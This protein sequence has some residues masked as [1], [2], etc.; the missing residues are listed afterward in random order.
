[1]VVGLSMKN[2]VYRRHDKDR[3]AY[4]DEME[5]ILD[6]LRKHGEIFVPDTTIESLYYDFSYAKYGGGWI[7][8]N[9]QILEEFEAWLNNYE[10]I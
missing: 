3:F 10:Y 5:K 8:V 1:M 9:K 2:I 4:P 6:Y 7:C